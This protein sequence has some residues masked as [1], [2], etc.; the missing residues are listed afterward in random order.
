MVLI[1]G[2]TN[3]FL[4]KLQWNCFFNMLILSNIALLRQSIKS[5]FAAGTSPIFNKQMWT[6]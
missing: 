1:S 3:A 4:C 5:N 6:G 2:L